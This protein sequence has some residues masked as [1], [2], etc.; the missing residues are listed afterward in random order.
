[1]KTKKTDI[2]EP[3]K[4]NVVIKKVAKTST[5]VTATRVERMTDVIATWNEIGVQLNAKAYSEY[6]A[7]GIYI[8]LQDALKKIGLA[9]K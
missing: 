6:E 8:I 2:T 7:N 3:K 9:D 4:S 1:M 5:Q